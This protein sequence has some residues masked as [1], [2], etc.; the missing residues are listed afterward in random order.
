MLKL[1]VLTHNTYKL[2]FDRQKDFGYITNALYS[3]KSLFVTF[4]LL[5]EIGQKP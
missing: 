5:G 2:I 3:I 4:G 1:F